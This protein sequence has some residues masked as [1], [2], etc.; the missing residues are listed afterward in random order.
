MKSKTIEFDFDTFIDRAVK[1]T[2]KKAEG[3]HF[4]DYIYF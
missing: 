1:R 2:K 3:R 4:E